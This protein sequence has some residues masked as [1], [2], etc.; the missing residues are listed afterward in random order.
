MVLGQRYFPPRPNIAFW[1]KEHFALPE[2]ISGDRYIRHDI[3]DILLD[4]EKAGDVLNS[5]CETFAKEILRHG[6]RKVENKDIRNFVEQLSAPAHYWSDLES[7]F[8]EILRDYTLEHD[9]D[10]IRCQ[11]LKSVRDTLQA[12]WEQHRTSVSMGDAWAIRALVKAEG[13]V[14]RK[15]KEFN[16]E[17]Q[18]YEPHKEEA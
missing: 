11:W 17:I 15:L 9:P 16:D 6:N 13:P 8:H 5:A 18:K 2:A 14:F 1:R 3:R 12:A 7:G 10:V 4:A